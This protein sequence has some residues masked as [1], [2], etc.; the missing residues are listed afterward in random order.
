MRI[1]E[2]LRPSQRPARALA[3]FV[4][5]GLVAVALL[6]LAAVE[7]MRRSGT[8]EAV[9][10]AKQTTR[11]AADGIVAPTITPALLHCDPQA[12]KKMDARVRHSILGRQ[13]VRVKIWNAKGQI[14][15]SDEHRLIGHTYGLGKEEREALEGQSVD[16]ELSNLSEPENRYE[17]NQKKLLEVYQGVRTPAGTPLLIEAYNKFSSVSASGR[18]LW[19]VFAPAMIGALLLLQA[20]QIPLAWSLLPRPQRRHCE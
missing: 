6:G 15:Y 9:R 19:L 20:A 1:S 2:E 13:V 17:R 18:R 10:D 12:I 8:D 14:V 16:A 11:L 7:V 5:S 4:L 3:Q